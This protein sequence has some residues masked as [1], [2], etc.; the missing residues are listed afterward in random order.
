MSLDAAIKRLDRAIADISSVVADSVIIAANDA[1]SV[2]INRVR[3]TGK[4]DKGNPFLPDYTPQYKL[5]KA[6]LTKKQ[7]ER[8]NKAVSSKLEAGTLGKEKRDA[9]LLDTAVGIRG[10]YRGFVDFTLT[11]RMLNNIG[12]VEKKED[13]TKVKV[14]VAPR[15]DENKKKLKYNVDRRGEI[16]A[17]SKEELNMVSDAFYLRTEKEIKKLLP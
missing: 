9:K 11:G 5:R 12:I 2:I 7:I 4:N 16:L 10:R 13:R 15:A 8:A 1:T 6:G 3:Q 14:L 17:L